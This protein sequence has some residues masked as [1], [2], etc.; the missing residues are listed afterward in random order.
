MGGD[1]FP[2]ADRSP[3]APGSPHSQGS[4]PRPGT[5]EP[6]ST[7]TPEERREL[8]IIKRRTAFRSMKRLPDEIVAEYRKPPSSR[9]SSSPVAAPASAP[10]IDSHPPFALTAA[11]A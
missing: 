2:S 10:P 7:L 5:H 11:A 3:R 8:E 1:E 9:P 6:E 4:S